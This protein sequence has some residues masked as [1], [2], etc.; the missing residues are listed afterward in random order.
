M[1]I[2]TEAC[3]LSQKITGL[4]PGTYRFT[5][6]AQG[7]D[8]AGAVNAIYAVSSGVRQDA[9]F[10]LVG[11]TTW[12]NP[13]IEEIVVGEDGTVTIGAAL[14]LPSG[15][16]GTLDDFTLT[17]VKASDE[18][19]DKPSDE[20]HQVTTTH[21]RVTIVATAVVITVAITAAIM[22][23]VIINRKRKIRM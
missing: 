17:L 21:P 16:W 10:E 3:G 8:A 7:G 20:N 6:S 12:Q 18:D 23:A 19:N 15:A 11:W 5:V 4:K 14:S 1:K 2:L 9:S 22:A 13:V